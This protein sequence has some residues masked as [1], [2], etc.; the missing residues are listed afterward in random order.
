MKLTKRKTG[1]LKE[2]KLDKTNKENHETFT[3]K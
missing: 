2:E 3:Y 1:C